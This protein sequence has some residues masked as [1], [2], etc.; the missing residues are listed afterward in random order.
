MYVIIKNAWVFQ[1][2]TR[3]FVKQNVAIKGNKFYYIST[4]DIDDLPAKTI[5]A[6][7]QYLIAF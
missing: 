1:T 7:T 3:S 4:V 2:P 6:E 5:E